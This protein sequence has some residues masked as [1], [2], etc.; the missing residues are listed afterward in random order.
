MQ[1][2]PTSQLLKRAE[3]EEHKGSSPQVR[4]GSQLEVEGVC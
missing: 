2:I 4:V 3:V 1:I